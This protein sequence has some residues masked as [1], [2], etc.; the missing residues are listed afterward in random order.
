MQNL[1]HR[2]VGERVVE[3]KGLK[4]EHTMMVRPWEGGL[5]VLICEMEL[6]IVFNS[7]LLQIK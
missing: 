5:S 3:S 7:G 4:L 2:K 1:T 6:M